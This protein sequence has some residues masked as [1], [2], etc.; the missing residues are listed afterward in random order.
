[1][2]GM[3]AIIVTVDYNRHADTYACL[4]SL[5][6]SS[7][8]TPPI[9]VIDNGSTEPLDLT[10][11]PTVEL[12]RLE[13]NLGFAGGFNVGLRRALE[14]GAEAV[15][16]L[17]NDTFADPEMLAALAAELKDGVGLAGPRIFYAADPQR[18]WSDGFDAHPLT[19]ELTHGR[20]GQLE[21]AVSDC[22][23]RPVD[24][25]LGCAMLIRRDVLE[26]IGL[27]DERFFAY[28]EDLDYCRRAQAA[29]FRLVTVPAAR[30]WHNVASTTGL[31][32]P[33]RQY[34]LAY[35]SV[36]FFARHAGWRWP[37]VGLYRLGSTL[38]TVITFVLR[39]RP[40]L[41]RAHLRGLKDGWQSVLFNR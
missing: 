20:R 3:H 35:G 28:Y 40:D 32:H 37:I 34:L 24:Y 12:I 27:F 38:T 21:G 15:L 30:L 33:Q 9:I 23:T 25:V 16:V 26:T 7:G 13:R 10:A 17:N 11:Y 29:G 22:A 1:M 31:G 19:L 41:L 18:I 14:Q 36:L 4:D 6:S 39:R 8:S 5:L 2:A